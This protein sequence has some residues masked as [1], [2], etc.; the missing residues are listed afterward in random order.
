MKSIFYILFVLTNHAQEI[1]PE[2]VNSAPD[3]EQC[4]DVANKLNASQHIVRGDAAQAAG[5][6]FVCFEGTVPQ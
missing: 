3:R 5:A 4:E 2:I 1:Q 6:R